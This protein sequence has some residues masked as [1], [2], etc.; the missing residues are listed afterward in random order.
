MFN[1]IVSYD[2]I[3]SAYLDIVEKFSIDSK[4]FRYHGL[5]NISIQDRDLNSKEL[6]DICQKEL[7]ENREIEPA[8]IV[9]IPKKNNPEKFRDIFIYNIKDRIKAQAIYRVLLPEF[10]K[11]FS[12]R[13]FSYRPG[14]PPYFAAKNFC[15][16][17]RKNFSTDKALVLD[18]ENYSDL[19]DKNVLY[20]QLEN[21]FEDRKI[22]D[23][24]KLF[25]FNK[26]YKNGKI[27]APDIGLVQGVPL[28]ALFN[29]LYLTDLDH[30]YQKQCSFYIRIGDDIGIFDNNIDKLN[31]LKLEII[32]DLNIRNLTINNSKLFIGDAKENFSFLGYCFNSG[33]I[34]LEKS[35]I[36]RIIAGWKSI[37]KYKNYNLS[38]KKYLLRRIM[39]HPEKN[40]NYQFQKIIKDKPQINNSEQIKKLS[41]DFFR[42]LTDFI[43]GKYSPR[44]RRLLRKEIEY[45][46][47]NHYI[48]FI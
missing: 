11:V 32:K 34:S 2:N 8:L 18:L 39:G 15:H 12:K 20:S 30:K 28:I 41:E 13:L 27:E 38:K 9:S 33:I 46:K 6:I 1:K 29:N 7:V 44:N 25:I 26:I 40:F 14:K 37:L 35:Y 3:R 10:E 36:K 16:R 48:I 42:I 17:Y 24:L 4:S 43:F 19:I 22:L 45:L 5:D 47:I 21:I 31:K 23:L